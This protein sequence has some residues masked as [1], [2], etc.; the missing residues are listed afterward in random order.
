MWRFICDGHSVV[1]QN[2]YEIQQLGKALATEPELF[3]LIDN[4]ME[5]KGKEKA[6]VFVYDWI[7]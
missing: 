1:V 5:I 6:S 2:I 7:N 3:P 4:T